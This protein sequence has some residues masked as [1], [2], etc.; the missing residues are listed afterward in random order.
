MS[1]WWRGSKGNRH[2]ASLTSPP[3]L[4]DFFADQTGDARLLLGRR[5][6]P[7]LGFPPCDFEQQLG[8]DRLLELLAVLD[9]D[10]EGAGASD[11]AVLVVEIEVVDVHRRIGWLLHHDRQAV[12]GD[13]LLQRR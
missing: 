7:A 4:P 10:H 12:D 6:N 8:T 3:V 1:N 5:D 9:R 13:A 2:V 11:D